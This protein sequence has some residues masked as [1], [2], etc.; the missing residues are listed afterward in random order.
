MNYHMIRTDD[1]LNGEGLRVVLFVSGCNNQ[2]DECHNPETWN[3]KSGKEFDE[4]ALNE[5]INEMKKDYIS[6]L[7]I[8]GGD[9]LY[10][11]NLKD[12][13][14]IIKK[15]KSECAEKTIWLYTGFKWEDFDFTSL[16]KTNN[17]SGKITDAAYRAMIVSLCDVLVDGKFI[18]EF[19][20]VNYP[21]AGSTNQRVINVSESLK[22]IMFK[23]K[24]LNSNK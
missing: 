24:Q 23:I 14:E 15:V 21:W 12:V 7:T 5:I 4:N 6:G 3:P 20:D 22:Q 18:K 9:P 13:Y 2:C 8:S 10:K 17:E 11:D 1:M 19:A 16:L